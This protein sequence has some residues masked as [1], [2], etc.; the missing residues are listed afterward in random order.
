M[1]HAQ[2]DSAGNSARQPHRGGLPGLLFALLVMCLAVVPHVTLAASMMR[3]AMPG[4]ASAAALPAVSDEA[5]TAPCHEDAA[6][7]TTHAKTPPCCIVG[8]GLIAEAPSA[9][10][11]LIDVAWSRAIPP[12]AAPIRGLTP[13]PAEHPPRA[14]AS[15]V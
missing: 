11:L 2:R 4:H 6:G 12:P 9:P 13:E 1:I 8:C 15:I 10:L 7:A 14:S 5:G 3:A